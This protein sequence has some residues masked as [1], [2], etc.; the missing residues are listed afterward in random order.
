M[1]AIRHFD[2]N[3]WHD[4][5][6]GNTARLRA[7]AAQENLCVV[8]PFGWS[9]A[10]CVEH[11]EISVVTYL[12]HWQEGMRE[13][14]GGPGRKYA[15]WWRW[16]LNAMRDRERLRSTTPAA[17]R[18]YRDVPLVLAVDSY[19]AARQQVPELLRHMLG[20]DIGSATIRSP[21]ASW[22]CYPIDYSFDLWLAHEDRHLEQAEA[23]A[24]PD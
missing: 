7:L 8:N 4:N 10:E 23:T 22:L 1:Q 12:K 21:F 5:F 24:R 2:R 15:I 19:I 9:A 18:P 17:F 14:K 11:L 16:F 20:Q 6:E 13:P 3:R